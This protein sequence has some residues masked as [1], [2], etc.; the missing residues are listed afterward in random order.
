MNA[1]D[2]HVERSDTVFVGDAGPVRTITLNRPQRLNAVTDEMVRAL[3]RALQD[4]STDT[5]VRVVL[6]R[7]A[8]RAFSS[9]HDLK[10]PT[11]DRSPQDT[12]AR[13]ERLQ[14][15]TRLLGAVPVPV[16]AVVQ[17]WAVGA[18]AELAIGCDLVLA[19]RGTRFR[20]PE[21]GLG[22]AMT[23]GASRTLTSALGPQR[24]KRLV[25]LGEAI[26]AVELHRH[27]LVSHLVAEDELE[28][29]LSSLTQHLAALPDVATR[30]GKYLLDHGTDGDLEQALGREVEASLDLRPDERTG[31]LEDTD[32]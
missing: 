1:P 2:Q 15:V 4:A 10:E 22:L 11:A 29:E 25:L 23:N 12:R 8:G 3:S 7:G 18:G 31:T 16:V 6:L 28:D 24:A 20:F 19:P 9:G 13:L 32:G 30:V 27:G 21:V 17:G 26:D 5:S 14:D